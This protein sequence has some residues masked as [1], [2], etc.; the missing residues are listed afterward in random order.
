MKS[1]NV[2]RLFKMKL[3]LKGNTTGFKTKVE[4]LDR[5]ELIKW[6]KKRKQEIL[7][8]T[9]FVTTKMSLSKR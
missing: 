5:G 3:K 4:K 9:V 1:L 8:V 7:F 2:N 6:I